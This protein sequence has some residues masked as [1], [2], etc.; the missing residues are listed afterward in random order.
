MRRTTDGPNVR[1][2]YDTWRDFIDAARN[3]KE[4]H[5]SHAGPGFHGAQSFQDAYDLARDGWP[6]GEQHV[7]RL[8]LDLFDKV[9]NLIERPYPVYDV[10]GSEIDV[11]R[12]LDGEPECWQR[13][14]ERQTEGPGR[15][16]YRLVFNC[17][18]SGGVGQS[19]ITA[20]G[21]GA[22][23]LAELLEY[24]GHGV[25]IVLAFRANHHHREH[26]DAFVPLKACEQPLD[27]PRLAFALAHPSTLRRFMF[28]AM[29]NDPSGTFHP[30]T[31]MPADV[32]VA[33]RGDLFFGHAMYG[34]P[35]WRNS[36]AARAWIIETLKQQGVAVSEAVA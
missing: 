35:N 14:E 31:D 26:L 34:D 32:D 11:A 33:D 29:E 20:R 12:Y 9:S 22:V 16:V 3:G 17:S 23:A 30:L 8:S 36:E 28:S 4:Q 5:S 13:M 24:A 15:R 19:V 18:V 10:E 2:Q 21:A 25:E 7:K 1:I 6:E 27:I